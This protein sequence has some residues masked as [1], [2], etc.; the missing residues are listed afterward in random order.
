LPIKI[1][2]D[3]LIH[4]YIIYNT[5]LLLYDRPFVERIKK[6][7]SNL[8]S[9]IIIGMLT[10]LK[11]VVQGEKQIRTIDHGDRKLMFQTNNTKDII[12]ALV[13]KEDLIVFQRKLDA[14]IKEFDKDYKDLVKNINQTSCN[15]SNWENL[16]SL[17]LKYFVIEKPIN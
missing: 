9:G 16:E 14:L 10:I 5:G 6:Y 8:I 7:D 17:I 15:M 2:T 3:L 12:F 4:I 11:E 13:V 1:W